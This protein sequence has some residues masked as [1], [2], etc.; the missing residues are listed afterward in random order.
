MA[1]S[2]I[3]LAKMLWNEMNPEEGYTSPHRNYITNNYHRNI[4]GVDTNK[5]AVYKANPNNV[6][7]INFYRQYGDYR[8]LGKFPF[9][10]KAN[11]PMNSKVESIGP[12]HLD[13]YIVN[14]DDVK[15]IRNNFD[16]IK[17]R[18]PTKTLGK[19]VKKMLDYPAVK[20]GGRV[21]SKSVVPLSILEGI[22]LNT[23]VY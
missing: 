11:V 13:A 15:Y 12:R 5:A 21:V 17:N 20:A 3:D 22:G 2:W 14:N 18:I 8:P 23:P 19:M 10:T 4:L 9:M 7:D 6:L 16:R 1:E